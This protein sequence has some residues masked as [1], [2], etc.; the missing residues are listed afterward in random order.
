M[1]RSLRTTRSVVATACCVLSLFSFLG[2]ERDIAPEAASAV[3]PASPEARM[4]DPVY[5]QKLDDL[6]AARK[7]LLRARAQ[8]LTE[9]DALRDKVRTELAAAGGAS[10]SPDAVQVEV[11]LAKRP[12]WASLTNR[13]AA[14]E[15]ALVA[16]RR[17][18]AETIRERM[19]APKAASDANGKKN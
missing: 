8:V 11:A 14:A 2:C 6:N 9:M 5:R 16:H 1:A 10:S 7:P 17:R 13:L 19:T 18:V 4:K 12:A 15:A 3:D